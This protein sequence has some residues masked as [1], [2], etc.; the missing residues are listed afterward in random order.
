[1]QSCNEDT[2]CM[3]RLDAI[4]R[5]LDA[6]FLAD[7]FTAQLHEAIASF[8]VPINRTNSQR[9]FLDAVGAFVCHVYA[10]GLVTPRN[11]TEEQGREEAL[12]LLERYYIG[13][14][15]RG[16]HAAL[17]EGT[18]PGR[19]GLGVVL[20]ALGEFIREEQEVLYMH[21][22]LANYVDHLDWSDKRRLA[23]YIVRQLEPFLPHEVLACSA[24]QLAH[25]CSD[26]LMHHFATNAAL[27]RH[28]TGCVVKKEGFV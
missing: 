18:S 7:V 3:E 9:E 21:W 15:A 25:A 11:L 19:E 20:S 23:R 22:V 2:D 8:A 28:C 6:T 5:L 16:Y 24:G 4:N 14:N 17:V 10:N 13:A 12:S 1:M 26:L 27:R